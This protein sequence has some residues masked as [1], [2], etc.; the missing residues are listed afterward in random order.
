V[1]IGWVGKANSVL[2]LQTYL[3]DSEFQT[4]FGITKEEFYQQ[5]RWKQ[6]QQK[7]KTDLF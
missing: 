7:R 2:L 1:F 5:P 6:E 3:S 4:V